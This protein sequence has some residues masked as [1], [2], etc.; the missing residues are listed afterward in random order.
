[1]GKKNLVL[2]KGWVLRPVNSHNKRRTILQINEQI[3]PPELEAYKIVS[4]DTLYLFFVGT[5][6]Y[7][8]ALER[9]ERDLNIIK[10]VAGSNNKIEAP[11]ILL[12][13]RDLDFKL[14][15]ISH[16]LGLHKNVSSE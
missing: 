5:D 15:G 13:P 12:S 1:M 14:P 10:V 11:V 16:V 6:L 7:P 9:G 8:L 4:I 2:P 3:N